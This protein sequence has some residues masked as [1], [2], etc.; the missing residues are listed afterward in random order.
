[1]YL[2]MLRHLVEN[3]WPYKQG[4]RRENVKKNNHSTTSIY[5]CDGNRC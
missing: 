5:F 1:M 2:A 3:A 4:I